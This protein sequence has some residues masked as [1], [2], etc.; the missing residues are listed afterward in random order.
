[1]NLTGGTITP[2]TR[3][4]S[5]P[6]HHRKALK[7]TYTVTCYFTHIIQASRFQHQAQLNIQK[8]L[9]QYFPF[10]IRQLSNEIQIAIMSL[11]TIQ[12]VVHQYIGFLLNY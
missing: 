10:S 6:I 8:S 12:S 1:M 11:N 7:N 4:E 3:R 9:H 5:K 2:T